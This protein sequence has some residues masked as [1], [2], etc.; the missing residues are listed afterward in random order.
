MPKCEEYRL[1]CWIL[2]GS[3]C[4][5]LPSVVFYSAF[6]IQKL[7]L[8]HITVSLGGRAWSSEPEFLFQLFYVPKRKKNALQTIFL[9]SK[10]AGFYHDE[11]ARWVQTTPVGCSV[12]TG[13]AEGGVSCLGIAIHCISQSSA[14]SPGRLGSTRLC[15]VHK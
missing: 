2:E 14:L 10:P 4:Q 15:S 7:C 12:E 11:A 8:S 13:C 1:K 6:L 9:K 3:I 5:I